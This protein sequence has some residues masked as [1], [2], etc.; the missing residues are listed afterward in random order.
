MSK[1]SLLLFD[2][3]GTLTPPRKKITETMLFFLQ[4]LTKKENID[5]GFVGGSNLEKQI[6]QLGEDNFYLFK[7]RFSENGLESY[8]NDELIKKESFSKKFGE[9]NFKKLIN[10]CLY[11]LSTIDTPVKRGTF[12][13]CRNGMLNI[14]PIGRSCSQEERDDFEKFDSI[15]NLRKKM[16]SNIQLLW[17]E[18]IT[19]NNLSDLKLNFSIG[20]QISVDVFPEGWDKTYCLQFLEN[21]YDK[22]H[23]FGDK[24][25]KNGNDYEIYIDARVIGHKV[26]DY[27]DTI[28][29]LTHLFESP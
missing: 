24:T 20:G 13:E 4:E 3:D 23:F 8:Y 7:W 11:V 21:K 22:I 29:I 9:D 18:Y 17:D 2:I 16:I 14:S 10:I 12:I 15:N 27:N 28:N 6:E 19:S 26:I 1:K 5:L 25:D